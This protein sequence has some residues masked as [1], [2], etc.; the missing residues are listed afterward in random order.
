[1]VRNSHIISTNITSLEFK[2]LD[3]DR[4]KFFIRIFYLNAFEKLKSNKSLINSLALDFERIK[5]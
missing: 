4:N 2:F 1:M 3:F 5:I